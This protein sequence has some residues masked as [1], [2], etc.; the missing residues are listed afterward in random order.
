MRIPT[1]ALI[2]ALVASP[3]LAQTELSAAIPNDLAKGC[4]EALENGQNARPFVNELLRRVEVPLGSTWGL[5]ALLCINE[6][7]GRKHRYVDRQFIDDDIIK[8]REQVAKDREQQQ[9]D[10]AQRARALQIERESQAEKREQAYIFAVVQA[11]QQEYDKDRFRA[12]T[13]PICG[14]VFKARGLPD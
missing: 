11:C 8:E 7:T 9:R 1:L 3:A 6:V 13:T 4:K 5:E 12:L 14:E 2:A 10:A